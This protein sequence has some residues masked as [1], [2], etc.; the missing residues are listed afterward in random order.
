MNDEDTHR[1]L[2]QLFYD[3]V[4]LNIVWENKPSH[5]KGINVRKVLSEI[6]RVAKIRRGEIMV[7][8]EARPKCK[9]EQYKQAQLELKSQSQAPTDDQA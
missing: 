6:R 3:Y 9:T 4:K 8:R 1:Q 2:L 5:R 7:V